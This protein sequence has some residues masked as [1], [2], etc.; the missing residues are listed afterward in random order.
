MSPI[1][2]RFVST[3]YIAIRV[4]WWYVCQQMPLPTQL[5]LIQCVWHTRAISSPESAG[6][7]CHDGH[8]S[9]ITHR[10]G[11]RPGRPFTS[12][13][14]QEAQIRQLRWKTTRWE[15]RTIR[16]HQPRRAGRQKYEQFKPI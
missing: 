9:Y 8:W 1:T 3:S 15:H 6:P 5:R 11:A 4:E 2:P 12:R 10:A 7:G 16:G 13:Q 14:N